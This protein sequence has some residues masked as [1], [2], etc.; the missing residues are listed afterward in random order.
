MIKRMM[1]AVGAAL[2]LA[3]TGLAQP[4]AEVPPT[5]PHAAPPASPPSF[6]DVLAGEPVDDDSNAS[7][8]RVWATADYLIAFMTGTSLP[9]LVTT[10]PAGTP[11][12]TAGVLGVPTTSVLVEGGV[13]DEARSGVRFGAGAWLDPDRHLGV[14]A[15]FTM[16]ESQSSIFAFSSDGST[17]LARPFFNTVLQAPASVLVAFPGSSSG[18][19]AVQASSGNFYDLNV[20]LTEC[21]LDESWI[22]VTSLFGYRFIR[23]DDALRIQ[24]TVVP[25]AA[26]VAGT[27][28]QSIDNFSAKNTFNGGDFGFRA[29]FFWRALS[30]DTLGKLAVGRMYR[31]VD[32][33]GGQQVLVPGAAAINQAGGVNALVSNIGIFPTREWTVLPEIGVTL[34]WQARSNLRFRLGYSALFLNDIARA[35]DHVDPF[36]NPNLFPPATKFPVATDRPFFIPNSAAVT[37]HSISIGAELT[38]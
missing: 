5:V 38:Y 36:I 21:F 24:Q 34:G 16:L 14:E 11:R 10:S 8:A 19:I 23:Y 31:G 25:A 33:S 2:A 13:N 26:P 3:G 7:P 1:V 15:G 20:D 6:M 22:Q 28:I 37:I 27:Q 30:L 9:P 12:A 4:A 18:G 35:D 17:I 32:I 29:R